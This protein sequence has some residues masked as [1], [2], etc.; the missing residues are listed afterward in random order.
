VFTNVACNPGLNT[1]CGTGA[2]NGSTRDTDWFKIVIPAMQTVTIC[3]EAEFD[4]LTGIVNNFGVDSCAG[5]TAFLV[6]DTAD[7][8]TLGG[9]SATLA[10]GTWYLFV[11]PQFN[12][13]VLCGAEYEARI[14]CDG[15]SCVTPCPVT[16]DAGKQ[17]ENEPNCGLPEDT[18]NGGC[19]VTPAVFTNLACVP[20]NNDVCG[21]VAFD[22]T[23]RDT[24]WYR[25]VVTSQQDVRICVTAE[26]EV[27]V[28]IINTFG[29]D[30]CP[31]TIEFLASEIGPRCTETCVSTCL[32]PGT[33]YFLVAPD[34]LFPIM[35]GAE[36]TATISCT[37]VFCDPTGACCLPFDPCEDGVDE[38]TCTG[39]GGIFQGMGVL[40]EDIVCVCPINCDP[41][42][43]GQEGVVDPDCGLAAGDDGDGGCN[44]TGT[45]TFFNLTGCPQTVCGSAAWNGSTRDTDWYR[46]NLS[47]ASGNTSVMMTVS[48]E[49]NCVFGLIVGGGDEDCDHISGVISP[50][51]VIDACTTGS[52]TVCLP[53]GNWWFFV[54]PSNTADDPPF[55]CGDPLSTYS[56]T[57][58]CTNPSNCTIPEGACCFPDASCS[59]G[60]QFECLADGGVYQGNGSACASTDCPEPCIVNSGPT[61]PVIFNGNTVNLGYSSGNVTASL[62]QRW[63][64]EG[65]TLPTVDPGSNEYAVSSL[66]I[67]GFIP[68]APP[69][70]DNFD[71]IHWAIYSRNAATQT[72]SPPVHPTHVVLSGMITGTFN[73]AT[74]AGAT[75]LEIPVDIKLPPGDYWITVY[76]GRTGGGM[77]NFAWFANAEE[78]ITL[79]DGTGLFFWRSAM[80]PSPGYV[81]TTAP[82]TPT[83][84]TDP[85]D[86]YH[87]TLCV[88]GVFQPAVK[89]QC[90]F[91]CAPPPNGDGNRN[92]T[93][94]LALLAQYGAMGGPHACDDAPPPS[95]D[96]TV[97]VTDLLGLLAVYG[98]PCP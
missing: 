96:G 83:G 5:V 29:S 74:Y 19:N 67:E 46:L 50:A 31:G 39:I 80:Q 18:V 71:Q 2:F 34:F 54:G 90:P 1:V 55:A 69:E 66:D 14:S 26:F 3:V 95:G 20:P 56:V 93:D 16:C 76:A 94:L 61:R 91:D 8:C 25:V 38:V 35:C 65:F 81:R 33:W 36:Y 87:G 60:T 75:P 43:P 49:F 97:N 7:A 10:A 42:A 79:I 21:T 64:V 24:D 62:P 32:S 73:S 27:L 86:L 40:C 82:A 77:A 53:P 89:E 63:R 37:G 44:N 47:G 52:V 72:T 98:V 57:F 59:D 22:G 12:D 51:A 85:N 48:A 28:G 6:F 17:P 11:A 92:V 4:V 13:V 84:G 41:T 45:P 78:G 88:R 9:T 70:T 68:A 15:T 58:E 23:T 30:S